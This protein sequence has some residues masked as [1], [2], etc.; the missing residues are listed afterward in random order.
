MPAQ[1]TE[2]ENSLIDAPPAGTALRSSTETM[3][4][5]HHVPSDLRGTPTDE[6]AEALQYWEQRLAGA[7]PALDLPAD[8][9][10]APQHGHPQQQICSYPLVLSR[11]VVEALDALGAQEDCA[12]HI[13]LLASFGTLL[14]RYTGQSDVLIQVGVSRQESGEPSECEPDKWVLRGDWSGNPSFRELVRR[15]RDSARQGLAHK[16]PFD[17]LMQRLAHPDQGLVQ[18]VSQIGFLWNDATGASR[19]EDV[20]W[21]NRP[22][23]RLALPPELALALIRTDGDVVGSFDYRAD[24]FSKERIA[25]FVVHWKT[26][27]EE[28]AAAPDTRLSELPVLGADERQQVLV[29]WN[30]TASEYERSETVVSLFESQ[31]ARTTGARALVCEGM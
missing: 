28:A 27:V 24:L 19:S 21:S 15:I 14:F 30:D 9:A 29:E 31:V 23:H 18:S 7:P 11:P 5:R 13:T 8:H 12:P 3:P 4:S 16:L 2:E 10:R 25:R 17:D 26:L 20:E 22:A 6:L 1:F